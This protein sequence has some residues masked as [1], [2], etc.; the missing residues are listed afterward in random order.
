M[1]SEPAMSELPHPAFLL[2]LPG[3]LR[4]RIWEYAL[5]S[6]VSIHHARTSRITADG[7]SRI[8]YVLSA[9]STIAT[10]DPPTQEGPAGSTLEYNNI[11]YVNRQLYD[12]TANLEM[13]YNKIQFSQ[14]NAGEA[15]ALDQVVGYTARLPRKHVKWLAN[16]I[17]EPHADADA[18][19]LWQKDNRKG[20][21]ELSILIKYCEQHP[22]VHI[23]YYHSRWG[24][25]G[26][27]LLGIMQYPGQHLC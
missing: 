26:K 13:K 12:E 5:T 23:T 8:S 21:R 27:T 3:E 16:V 2:S 11:K 24:G 10:S 18:L 20:H 6:S 7:Q 9:C 25:A 17:L 14:L 15:S 4:N 22:D 1:D 19:R